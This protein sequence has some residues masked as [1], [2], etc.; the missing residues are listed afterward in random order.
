VVFIEGLGL[1]V[2]DVVHAPMTARTMQ[3]ELARRIIQAA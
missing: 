1:G 2:E 3:Q